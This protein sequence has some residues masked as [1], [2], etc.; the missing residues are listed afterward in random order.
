MAADQFFNQKRGVIHKRKIEAERFGLTIS[1]AKKILKQKKS[2]KV[3][4]NAI[5]FEKWQL[6]LAERIFSER[7]ARDKRRNR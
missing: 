3:S 1:D 6:E 5:Q 7:E 2:K 4:T